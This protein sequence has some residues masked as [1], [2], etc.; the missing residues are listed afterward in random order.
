MA[1]FFAWREEKQIL[2]CAL[3]DMSFQ[4]KRSGA[5]ACPERSEGNLVLVAA[6]GRA[7][8]RRLIF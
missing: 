5:R 8:V 2:R 6:L 7:V 1:G 3:N 4:V